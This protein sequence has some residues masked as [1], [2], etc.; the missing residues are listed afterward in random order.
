MLHTDCLTD[1]LLILFRH[2][3]VVSNFDLGGLFV[4]SIYWSASVIG[5]IATTTN[6]AILRLTMLIRNLIEKMKDEIECKS[7]CWEN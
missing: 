5:P 1:A 3:A 2:L 7:L 4:Q 6:M